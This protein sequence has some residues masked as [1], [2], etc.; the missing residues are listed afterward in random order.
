MSP[1]FICF[2]FVF[3]II[4]D[5]GPSRGSEVVMFKGGGNMGAFLGSFWD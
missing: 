5:N 1:S 2:D 3:D 4:E